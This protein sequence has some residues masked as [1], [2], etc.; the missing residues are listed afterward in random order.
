MADPVDGGAGSDREPGF[1]ARAKARV[2]PAERR[3][4]LATCLWLAAAILLGGFDLPALGYAA[5]QF[6]PFGIV[7]GLLGLLYV[8]VLVQ[9]GVI[10]SGLGW[11]EPLLLIYWTAA[12]AMMFRVLL[13]A[14]GLVQVALVVGAVI[15][16]GII[17]SRDDRDEAVLWLGSVAVVLAVLRFALVPVFEVRSG[18]PDWGPLDLG[19]AANALR[20]IFVAY[21]PQR[22]AAQA[23]HFGALVSYALGLKVQW[24]PSPATDGG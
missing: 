9:R 16:A 2:S 1:A 6:A 15:A 3:R 11:I 17:V 24:L 5:F 10:W 12:T 19:A 21:A 8:F 23:L 4:A 18:L 7:A 20:D 14:P 22:P 13:P